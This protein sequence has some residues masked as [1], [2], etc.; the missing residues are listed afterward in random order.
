MQIRNHRPRNEPEATSDDTYHLE[1]SSATGQYR[2]PEE[3]EGKINS[4]LESL[5]I[6]S[7]PRGGY[8]GAP[9][10]YS[11][12]QVLGNA[13]KPTIQVSIFLR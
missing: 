8:R 3:Y 9:L 4:F 6:L 10:K 13:K 11:S 12:H 7:G 5:F 1:V 2:Y